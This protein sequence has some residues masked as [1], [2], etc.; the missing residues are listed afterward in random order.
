MAAI[1]IVATWWA[2]IGLVIGVNR[3]RVQPGP[4]DG[5]RWAAAWAFAWPFL[6]LVE[7]ANGE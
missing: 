5:L 2:G 6:W 3:Q 1:A 7:S 4:A